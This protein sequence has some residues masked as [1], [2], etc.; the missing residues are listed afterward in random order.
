[1]VVEIENYLLNK[2]QKSYALSASLIKITA[3]KLRPS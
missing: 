2:A 3:L 1:M